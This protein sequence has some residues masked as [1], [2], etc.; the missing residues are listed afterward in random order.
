MIKLRDGR[1]AQRN[2]QVKIRE[3]ILALVLQTKISKQEILTDYL[4]QTHFPRSVRGYRQACLSFF[5]AE[6]NNL[7]I[8]HLVTLYARAKYPHRRNLGDYILVILQHLGHTEYTSEDVAAIVASMQ[9]P[10]SDDGQWA[11]WE[12]VEESR[13]VTS[14]EV[15]N[16]I[17]TSFDPE[18][19]QFVGQS[20]EKFM[21]YLTKYEAQDACVIVMD[22]ADVIAA[23][24]ARSQFAPDA[25][26]NTCL[27]PR[28]I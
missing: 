17:Q 28:Q 7:S 12:V 24:I 14:K 22:G 3:N 20:I 19:Q 5:S 10:Q 16:V 18:L 6:C 23:D 4:N 26:I 8:G 11:Y 13:S 1:F 2:R 15:K 9:R 27:I 21:P 25:T